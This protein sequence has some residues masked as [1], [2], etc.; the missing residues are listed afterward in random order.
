MS[1]KL[2]S[3]P[4]GIKRLTLPIRGKKVSM[5]N[6]ATL[7]T[8]PYLCESERLDIKSWLCPCY[9]TWSRSLSRAEFVSWWTQET[10]NLMSVLSKSRAWR[11]VI[12][13]PRLAKTSGMV[14][15]LKPTP[16]GSWR[17]RTIS[18]V[19]SAFAMECDPVFQKHSKKKR[20]TKT[21]RRRAKH[22][23]PGHRLRESSTAVGEGRRKWTW[24]GG[25]HT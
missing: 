12:H 2:C 10:V 11:T 15:L 18:S 24:A 20:W 4:L 23:S 8:E 19:R 25:S 17:K 5:G 16:V 7:G 1:F 21:S 13:G 22:S 14:A 9:V 3:Y 6:R